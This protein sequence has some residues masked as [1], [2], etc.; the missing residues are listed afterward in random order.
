MTK[1]AIMLKT[2]QSF[3]IAVL[4]CAAVFLV[5][6]HNPSSD[7][8]KNVVGDATELTSDEVTAS[9]EYNLG[10]VYTDL[11]TV[12]VTKAPPYDCIISGVSALLPSDDLLASIQVSAGTD[13]INFA[14]VG[15]S[16]TTDGEE[17]VVF[18][19]SSP[20][21][22]VTCPIKKGHSW[23]TTGPTSECELAG[24][25]DSGVWLPEGFEGDVHLYQGSKTYEY[26]YEAYAWEETRFTVTSTTVHKFTDLVADTYTVGLCADDGGPEAHFKVIGADSGTLYAEGEGWHGAGG[27]GC[28]WEVLPPPH[29]SF[30]LTANE[31]VYIEVKYHYRIGEDGYNAIPLIPLWASLTKGDDSRCSAAP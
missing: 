17:S 24:S 22:N 4:C 14:L 15:D 27:G 23:E 5:A 2:N 1:G 13:I 10:N 18:E 19:F 3:R 7:Q 25:G 31:D 26:E 11:A 29:V 21:S 20:E 6:C 28:R 30:D 9:T 12:F 16:S 8:Q